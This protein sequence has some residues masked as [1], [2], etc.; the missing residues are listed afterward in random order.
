MGRAMLLKRERKVS[1]SQQTYQQRN[2]F[3]SQVQDLAGQQCGAH[4]LDPIPYLCDG[5]QCSASLDGRPLYYDDDHLSEFGNRLLVPMFKPIFAEQ[6]VGE[7]HAAST[8]EGK[9]SPL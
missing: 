6:M 3:V 5:Q 9:Q 8:R 1:M 7:S 4:V 2:A